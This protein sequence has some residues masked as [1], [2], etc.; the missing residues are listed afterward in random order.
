MNMF[1]T[2]FG[3]TLLTLLLVFAGGFAG[4]PRGAVIALIVAGIGNFIAYFF[5]DRIVLAMYGAQELSPDQAPA[6]HRMVEDL[7]EKAGIPKPKIYGI[8]SSTP[9]AFATGRNPSHAAVAVTQGITS[10]LSER[11]LRGVL[12]HELGHVINRDILLSTLVATL[13]GA[14]GHLAFVARWFGPS[15]DDEDSG[16]GILGLLIVGIV[17]PIV[18]VMVQM[19]I[20][21]QREFM[22]DETGGRLCEDPVSLATALQHLEI[23]AKQV[24][25]DATPATAHMFIVNPL[26]GGGLM[27]LFSTHPSTEERVQRL[28]TLAQ[29]LGRA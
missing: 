11:E 13:A 28:M 3:L 19:F 16:G 20:S 12:A 25:M 15:R 24:P 9:N 1:K 7:A 29:D 14:I 21:R 4:G 6:I 18:A 27:S 5:S 22:A 23:G 2:M 10:M 26:T 17:L 8:P